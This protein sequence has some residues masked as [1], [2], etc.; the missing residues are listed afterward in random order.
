M[1]AESTPVMT[2]STPCHGNSAVAPTAGPEKLDQ[3]YLYRPES[4]LGEVYIAVS[5]FVASFAYLC[6]F[7]RF[8]AIE[9]D[10]GIILQGAQR[11]L[12]GDVL[13]GD[14]FRSIRR[15]PIIFWRQYSA[16]SAVRWSLRGL[17]WRFTE[18]RLPF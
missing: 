8:T 6:I 1:H 18:R 5:V 4:S 14:F 12:H 13:Y 2:Q 3:P 16:Y 11:I 9:P 7:R 10:E 17:P 15:G